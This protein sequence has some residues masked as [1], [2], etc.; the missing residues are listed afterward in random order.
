MAR[1][2]RIEVCDHCNNRSKSRDVCYAMN[3]E[4]EDKS[5]IPNWCPLPEAE[6]TTD[7]K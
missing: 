4:I 6:E 7:G 3:R 2:L 1:L 5:S